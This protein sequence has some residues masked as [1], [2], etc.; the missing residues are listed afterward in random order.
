MNRAII[1]LLLFASTLSLKA[2]RVQQISQLSIDS[3]MTEIGLL[4][5]NEIA[6]HVKLVGIGDV[7]T[8][9]KETQRFNTALSA[10]LISKKNFK[11]LLLPVDEWLIRPLNSY[12]QAA[13]PLDTVVLDSLL[14]NYL[15]DNNYHSVEFR[16]FIFWLKKHNLSHPKNMVNVFGVQSAETIPYSYFLAAYIYPVDKAS[17]ARLVKKWDDF[18]FNPADAYKDIEEW[19]LKM[20]QSNLSKEKRE[21]VKNCEMDIAHN[22][23]ILKIESLLQKFPLEVVKNY[24]SYSAKKTLERTTEK[25]ILF[26][27]NSTIVRSDFRSY[28]LIDDVPVPSIGKLLHIQLKADYYVCV[29]DAGGTIQIPLAD[30]ATQSIK[31]DTLS[32]SEQ[33]KDMLLQKDS[34]F[35]STDKQILQKFIPA[36]IGFLKGYNTTLVLNEGMAPSDAVFIFNTLTEDMPFGIN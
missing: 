4:M 12:L 11:N 7:A 17:G 36:A 33:V 20:K 19:Y 34:Y 22:K 30:L 21:L 25:S 10:F 18:V 27:P 2:Q 14:K 13:S 1:L 16:S 5:N 29:S 8:W 6:D 35:G 24:N 28:R 9:V 31:I 3:G 23:A 15:P 32:G 26:A